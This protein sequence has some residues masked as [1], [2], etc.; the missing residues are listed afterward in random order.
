VASRNS[1]Y[2]ESVTDSQSDNETSCSDSWASALLTEL[3]QFKINEKVRIVSSSSTEFRNKGDV[4]LLDDFSEMERMVASDEFR[5]KGD[6][7]EKMGLE[8]ALNELKRQLEDTQVKLQATEQRSVEL[9]NNLNLVNREKHTFEI[10]LESF[11]VKKGEVELQ[12]EKVKL[13]LKD[14][15]DERN[16]MESQLKSSRGENSKFREKVKILQ[17]EIDQEKALSTRMKAKLQKTESLEVEK[18]KLESQLLLLRKEVATW[19]E[20]MRVLDETL[21]NERALSEELRLKLQEMELAQAQ[22]QDLEFRFLSSKE[23][24]GILRQNVSSLQKRSTEV[25]AKLQEKVKSLEETLQ[26]ERALYKELLGKYKSIEIEEIKKKELMEKTVSLEKKIEEEEK[27]SMVYA[28]GLEA[29]ETKRNKLAAQY[30]I[31]CREIGELR[32]KLDT[33]EKE[34]RKEREIAIE[35]AFKCKEL[36]K[37]LRG[38]KEAAQ[39]K[40]EPTSSEDF[41]VKQVIFLSHLNKY[42]YISF[43]L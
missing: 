32:I 35:L 27:V 4:S 42:M 12:L 34:V 29:S 9:Q 40:A 7:M 8:R 38:I 41:K 36:E 14:L 37:E 1:T 3:D 20:K 23:E 22:K 39:V 25:E 2:T 28:A 30:E 10:E 18:R 11:E 43:F 16:E 24:V 6:G 13:E 31:S 21:E 17:R 19:R 26:K 33:L 5:N 15:K